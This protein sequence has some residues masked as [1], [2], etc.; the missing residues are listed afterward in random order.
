VTAWLRDAGIT[1]ERAR[2]PPWHMSS[3]LPESGGT[4]S[5]AQG[6]KAGVTRRG[7]GRR[8]RSPLPPSP[9][10]CP[11]SPGRRC[12]QS[13][14]HAPGAPT[15]ALGARTRTHRELG[16]GCRSYHG[17]GA[18]LPPTPQSRLRARGSR[19][20]RC[21][22]RRWGGGRQ[23]KRN[24]FIIVLLIKLFFKFPRIL[25]KLVGSKT[26]L[27]YFTFNMSSFVVFALGLFLMTG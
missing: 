27:R 22:A 4:T 24:S 21:G 20:Q 16:L 19:L 26:Y 23:A 13:D 6:R 11:S 14:P 1:T 3:P 9:S 8:S 17:D 15:P 7:W 12:P 18:A 25:L 5:A 2:V 10:P